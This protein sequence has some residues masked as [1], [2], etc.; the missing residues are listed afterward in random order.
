MWRFVYC[1]IILLF[2]GANAF[3]QSN[4]PA[5]SGGNFTNPPQKY[6]RG[7]NQKP[8]PDARGTDQSPLVVKVLPAPQDEEATKRQTQHDQE[9]ATNNWRIQLLTAIVG[10]AAFL[11]FCTFVVMIYRTGRQLRAYVL[12]EESG[13]R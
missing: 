2:L 4:R 9:E 11:Q 1:A 7:G 6:R 12:L 5:P 3:A 13:I 8:K 10:A